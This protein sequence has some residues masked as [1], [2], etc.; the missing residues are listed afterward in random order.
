[1]RPLCMQ[2][3]WGLRCEVPTVPKHGEH[4]KL[5]VFNQSK[6]SSETGDT[7]MC[8]NLITAISSFACIIFLPI[9]HK[10]SLS[11]SLS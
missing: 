7:G 11:F 9:R 2:E 4:G 1:M 8:G 3:R 5:P 10:F 6:R